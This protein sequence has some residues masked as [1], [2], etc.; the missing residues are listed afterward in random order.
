MLPAP[1]SMQGLAQE[2]RAQNLAML[3]SAIEGIPAITPQEQKAGNIPLPQAVA[4]ASAAVEATILAPPRPLPGGR[5]GLPVTINGQEAV[6]PL[7]PEAARLARARP[8]LFAEGKR[9]PVMLDAQGGMPRL[10]SPVQQGTPPAE[11]PATR[12]SLHQSPPANATSVGPPAAVA[13]PF[14][15]GSPGALIARI[16]GLAFPIAEPPIST[17]GLAAPRLPAAGPDPVMPLPQAATAS[18]VERRAIPDA[19]PASTILRALPSISLAGLP[20]VVADAAILASLRQSPIAPA[21]AQIIGDTLTT[22]PAARTTP[23]QGTALPAG[24]GPANAQ[25]APA[26]P[27]PAPAAQAPRV[28]TAL[29][30]LRLDATLPPT[31]EKVADLVRQSGVFQEA[32]LASGFLPLDQAGMPRDV[33]SLLLMAR[34]L[35]G[36]T[37]APPPALLTR[38]STTPEPGPGAA[39]AEPRSTPRPTEPASASSRPP[40]IVRV[41]EGAV[42]RIKLNQMA[43]LPTNPEV[44]ITDDRAKGFQLA[45]TIPLATQGLERAA[46]ASIGLVIQ[47]APIEDKNL[48]ITDDPMQAPAD[49]GFPWKVRI[50]LDLEETGP[51]QAEIGLRRQRVAITLWAERKATAARA[52]DEIGSLHAALTDAAF[53]VTTLDVRDGRPPGRTP[54]TLPQLDRRS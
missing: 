12:L 29:Q 41:I 38:G 31:G 18:T 25:T 8:E 19:S 7:P 50:A 3:I 20:P 9:L 48:P 17:P 46:T 26:L 24:V 16:T 49:E 53:E 14:P 32:Q 1:V 36:M 30:A 39:T 37:D 10:V 13:I 54:S 2:L 15:A 28:V 44:T 22:V 23:P 40:D 34:A 11:A 43:S 4:G 27:L 6:I 33:K 5:L 35:F 47:H 51:V 45:T 52:R 42:E 21:I